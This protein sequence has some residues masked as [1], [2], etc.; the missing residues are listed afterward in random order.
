MF[1]GCAG[2]RRRENRAVELPLVELVGQGAPRI[3]ALTPAIGVLDRRLV[4]VFEI[5]PAIGTGGMG[6]VHGRSMQRGYDS[7]AR[8]CQV[9]EIR[10]TRV[11][12]VGPDVVWRELADV[13]GQV[14]WMED[15]RAITFTTDQRA[16]EGT[17][18]DCHTVLGGPIR[19]TD[20]MT[21]TEWDPPRALSIR[22]LKPTTGT[23]RITL[24]PVPGGSTRVTWAETLQL[25]WRLGGPPVSAVVARILHRLW[26]RS[27][28]NLARLVEPPSV[29]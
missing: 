21:I 2:T 26:S 5:G 10:V 29:R 27:L 25:P 14:A 24:D 1:V 3:E 17:T 18:F 11:I 13:A 19:F 7:E 4:A 8:R 9:S 20:R 22:H 15:A 23:G 6:F 12:N 16:G 28:E